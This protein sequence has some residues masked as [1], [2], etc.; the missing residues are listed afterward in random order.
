[1]TDNKT[2]D[3]KRIAEA[4]SSH[5]FA[6]VYERLSQHVRWV[7]PGQVTVEGKEAVVA[8]CDSSLAEMNQLA[9]TEFIRFLSV[10]DDRAAAVDAVGRYVSHDGSIS[11]VSS[12][13]IYEFDADGFVTT[14]TSYAVELTP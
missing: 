11:E 9:R 13:D 3:G 4:F 2:R 12:A 14:I 10:A 5:R 8:A 1:M 7:I 6:E